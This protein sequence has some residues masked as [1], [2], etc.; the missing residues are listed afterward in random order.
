MSG[1]SRLPGFLRPVS[2]LGEDPSQEE[3]L[4]SHRHAA[5]F[6]AAALLLVPWTIWLFFA[7]PS[8]DETRHWNT[9]WSGFDT[10]LIVV[11]LGCALRMMRLSPRTSLVAAA[12]GALLVTDAWFDVMLSNGRT[13]L[14]E[15]LTMALLVE[16]PM[17]ALCFRTSYRA[18]SLFDQARP[19]LRSAGFRVQNGR[20]VPPVDW[21]LPA[22]HSTA[23]P[24]TDPTARLTE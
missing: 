19:Y 22:T 10:L 13:Q 7:L 6:L 3:H 11:F 8:R 2:M 17:A 23:G 4:F 1:T 24:A 14:L 18:L 15:A 9:A 21:P 5:F 16:L 20:L 12:A